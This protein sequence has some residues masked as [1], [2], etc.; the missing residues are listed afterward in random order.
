[1]ATHAR[2]TFEVKLTPQADQGADSAL[3]RMTIDKQWQG[4]LQGSSRGQMLTGMS[5]VAG[6]AAT[7][8]SKR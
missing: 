7:S 5:S 4:D 8:P 3:G 1:M 6:S 2:G